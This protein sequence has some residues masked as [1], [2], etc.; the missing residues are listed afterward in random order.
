MR[1]RSPYGASSSYSLRRTHVAHMESAVR[2]TI[3][4]VFE[5]HLP[6]QDQWRSLRDGR[7]PARS[8]VLQRRTQ[9]GRPS[10]LK[11]EVHPPNGTQPAANTLRGTPALDATYFSN[12]RIARS[13]SFPLHGH[14]GIAG[15]DA[16]SPTL[17]MT[18][19]PAPL[20]AQLLVLDASTSP[21]QPDCLRSTQRRLL[22]IDTP[23]SVPTH[24]Y[25]RSSLA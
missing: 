21:T 23:Q 3:P 7:R 10:C 1:R 17:A 13:T 12:R 16:P 25:R 15:Q 20:Q 9:G 8:Q 24:S 22:S 2:S 4:V 11:D 19:T 18:R 14:H 6:I 5:A